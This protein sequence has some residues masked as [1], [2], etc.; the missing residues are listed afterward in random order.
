MTMKQRIAMQFRRR[1]TKAREVKGRREENEE[2]KVL[3]D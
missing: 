2:K 3:K 1:N